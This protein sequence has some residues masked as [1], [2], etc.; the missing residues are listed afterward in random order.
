MPKSRALLPVSLVL[1][2]VS[3]ALAQAPVELRYTRVVDL[4]LPIESN[5][6]GIPGL[7]IYAENPSRVSIIAAMT[8]AQK[9]LLQKEGMTLSSTIEINNRSMISVLSIMSH[10]G[11]TSTRRAT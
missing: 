10:N 9:E 4:T 11:T 5:M 1:G 7:K 2:T 3:A 6:A 8:D